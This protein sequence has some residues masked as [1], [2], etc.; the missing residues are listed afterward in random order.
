MKIKPYLHFNAN[1]EEAMSFYKS[2]FGGELKGLQRFADMPGSEKMPAELLDKI[3]HSSLPVGK[4]V[5]MASDAMGSALTVGNNFSL[6]LEAESKKEATR[7]FNAL[8]QGGEIRR[9]I[10]QMKMKAKD[11]YWNSYFGACSDKYGINWIV[12]YRN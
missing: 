5:L 9:P 2:V 6:S 4:D 12:I 10:G 1:G 8:A 7:I 3:L 11:S